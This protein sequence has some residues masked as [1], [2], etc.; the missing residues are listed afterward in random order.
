MALVSSTIA[1]LINGVSQQPAAIRRASQAEAQENCYSSVSDGLKRRSPTEHVAKL[2]DGTLPDAF[3]HTIN[4]D[5][6]E[7]YN[8]IITDG[9][10]RVFDIDGVERTVAFPD[11]TTYLTSTVP[12]ESFRAVTI[13][14]FTFVVNTETD[15]AMDA[16]LSP[17]NGSEGIVFVREAQYQV[18]YE[19]Y[20]DGT[21]QATFTTGS[22]G[23]LS[24]QAIATNLEGDLTTNLGAGWTITRNGSTIHIVKDDDTSFTLE[25]RD[26]RAG[27]ALKAFKD[28]IQRFSDLPT[29]GPAG[30]TVEIVGDNTSNFDNYYVQFETSD[31]GLTFAEGVWRETVKPGIPWQLDSATMPHTLIR[32]ADNTFTFRRGAWGMREA[33]DEDSAPN[34]SFVGS[35]INDVSFFKNRLGFLADENIIMSRSSEFFEFFPATVTTTLDSDP[36]DVASSNNKVS[37]LRHAVAFNEQLLLFSDQTQFVFEGGDLLTPKT[38]SMSLATEFKSSLIAKPVNAGQNVF[39]AIDKGDFDSVREYFVDTDTDTNDAAEITAHI[40]RYVPSGIVKMAAATNEDLIVTLTKGNRKALYPYKYYWSGN[41]KLQSSWSRW[42]FN[43]A[44]ILNVDFI[45][46]VL[47]LIIQRSDGVYLEKMTVTAGQSDPGI[48]YLTH[49]DR[50]INETQ[51][52]L[53]SY[54]IGT[55]R[56]TWTLPYSVNPSATY[57]V[58]TRFSE[59]SGVNPGVALQG[60]IAAGTTI[61]ASGDHSTSPVWIGEVYNSSYTFSEQLVK[62]QSPGGGTAAVLTGRLQLLTWSITHNATGFYSIS[63]THQHREDPSVYNFTGRLLG[64]PENV[65]GEVSLEAGTFS[66]P[67]L[68]R[69]TET[70]ITVSSDAFLPFFL[71]SAEWEADFTIRS[72]RLKA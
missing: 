17:V 54:D 42:T 12:S 3:L 69:S 37:I 5:Q 11:G 56:T 28:K 65:L 2:L 63:V 35:K 21:E 41:E 23:T 10:L 14:D 70:T 7:R 48:N 29:V 32:E 44:D 55:N 38:A 50:R 13:A 18:T 53:V 33:G 26:T 30:F 57:A 31:P 8:V 67:V 58:A 49:L 36:I 4:R 61:S 46:S 59:G 15:V 27:T 34:P 1:N 62:E 9:D 52:T 25:A 20:V 24:T 16:S 68:G 60:V 71:L 66:F 43:D 72:T 19:V 39:F 6:L 40:P 51:A 45:D 47:Y 64:S 22:S